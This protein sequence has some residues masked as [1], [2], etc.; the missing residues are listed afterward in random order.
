MADS[1]VVLGLNFGTHDA[2]AALVCDGTAVA[3]AEEERFTRDK[4]TKKFPAHAIAYCLGEAGLKARDISHVAFF[5][6]PR[7]QLLLPPANLRQA[8]PASLGSLGSDLAKYAGRRSALGDIRKWLGPA[9]DAQVLPVRHHLAHAASAY[10]AS[11][12]REATVVT[13][14]GRGEYETACVFHGRD[15]T[16]TRRHAVLYPHSVGYLY[17]MMT[18]YLGFRP[19]RDEYKVM[20]LAAH[21]GPGLLGRARDLAAFDDETGRLRLNLAYFDH[22]RR[23]SEQRNLF[24]AR[25]T[26]MFGPPR[27]PGA[28]IGDRHRDLAFAIQRLTEELVVRYV[29]FARRNVPG[30]S[31]CMA[32]GVALNAVA[33]RAVIESGLFDEVFIQPAAGDAGT[34]LGSAL[35][36]S[37]K[38]T[39]SPAGIRPGHPALLGPAYSQDEIDAAVGAGLPP[40]TTVAATGDP[41][42]AAARLLADDKVI[43]WFQG[44]CEFGPRALGNRSI[45]AN[46]GN[47]ANTTRVNAFVKWREEFRPLAPAVTEEA[48][49]GYFRLHPAGRAVYPYMLATAAVRPERAQQIPA[50]VHADG[51]ARLQAVSRQQAPAFWSLIRAFGDLTG[52]PVVLNTSFNGPDEPIVCSPADA[53][54]AFTACGLDALV[55][56]NAVIRQHGPR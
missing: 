25:L 49:D 26:E 45:L 21:G 47:P 11:P 38:I 51:S 3:A 29:A 43:G 30:R 5:A 34:S 55:I 8:F 10:L 37:G 6:D 12:F 13:L 20:G 54:R 4:Q 56:G 53:V 27:E 23:P 36:V 7:L 17:S 52:V 40:G 46:P 16:L 18:R 33:N 1:P 32:G 31:L 44:R 50:V 14:D 39:G 41:A 28:P 48:A 2:A 24:S 42:G 35:W 22:H 9:G 15:G 19:Q